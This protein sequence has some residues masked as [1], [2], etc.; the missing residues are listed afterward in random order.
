MRDGR[1][2]AARDRATSPA[3]FDRV[4]ARRAV[5]KGMGAGTA[6]VLVGRASSSSVHPGGV[7]LVES[8]A[9]SIGGTVSELDVF[10]PDDFLRL[11]FRFVNLTLD[12][13]VPN[14]PVLRRNKVNKAALIVVEFA[15]QHV[16]EEVLLTA[17]AKANPVPNPPPPDQL[18]DPVPPANV[19][20]ASRL[21]GTSRLAFSVPN[22]VQ[23]I[24]FTIDGLLAWTA[25]SPVV[26][27]VAQDLPLV[28]QPPKLR[29]PDANETAI[30]APWWLVLSPGSKQAWAHASRAG[31]PQRA[32]R[33]V[34]HPAR[35][36]D[37]RQRR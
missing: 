25:L 24:P 9:V 22:N 20:I 23:T 34:A 2:R 4:V 19:G 30:E 6:L 21:S 36:E 33:A 17:G 14:Q 18:L 11:H 27:P 32:H 35:V 13:S 31:H 28:Y 12:A 37:E 16:A 3:L 29:K 15:P 10:R 8:L 1:A 5:L 7:G 26:V